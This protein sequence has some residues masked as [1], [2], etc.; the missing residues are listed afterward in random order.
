[1]T[2]TNTWRAAA[3][4]GLIAAAFLGTAAASAD[5]AAMPAP[6]PSACNTPVIDSTPQKVLRGDGTVTQ[7]LGKL[8]AKGID[9]RVRVLPTA[10]GGSLDSYEQS[11]IAGCPSWSLNGAIKPNLLVILV[12]LD[13]Q[14]AIFYGS[15][16]ARLQSHVDQIRADMGASFEAGNFPAGVAKGESEVYGTLYPS[17]WPTWAIA[18]LVM[19]I[20][21]VVVCVVVF[22]IGGGGGYVSSDVL[23]VH[24]S[25]W[26]RR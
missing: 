10:P 8:E 6:S 21:V 17:G 7:S 11:M 13:H 19:G 26:L 4:A 20:L 1:V 25:H 5:A 2:K 22:A 12:S 15:N 24:G 14:D 9:A 18:L 16:L 23:D 3:A